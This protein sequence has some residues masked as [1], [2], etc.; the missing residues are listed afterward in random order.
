M[1]FCSWCQ[2]GQCLA[3]LLPGPGP[4]TCGGKK[5]P[6]QEGTRLE[7]ASGKEGPTELSTAVGLSAAGASG[8]VGGTGAHSPGVGQA[9]GIRGG[10][11]LEVPCLTGHTVVISLPSLTW[12]ERGKAS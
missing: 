9:A 11:V 12:Q 3:L 1:D 2:T 8:R 4:H 5:G 10:G 7:V 6:I